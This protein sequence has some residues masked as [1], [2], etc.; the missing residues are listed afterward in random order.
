M[1]M[2][3]TKMNI[4]IENIFE[5]REKPEF[6]KIERERF[7]LAMFSCLPDSYHSELLDKFKFN[8]ISQIPKCTKYA[9]P[10]NLKFIQTDDYF[11]DWKMISLSVEIETLFKLEEAHFLNLHPVRY[12]LVKRAIA[13]GEIDMPIVYLCK[14]GYPRVEDGRHRIMALSKFGFT[15]VDIIVPE[16][17][18]A[19]IKTFLN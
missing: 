14:E 13:A 4:P 6:D 15:H 5:L 10:E 1:K 3:V 8:S 11:C 2:S 17:Q 16:E 18:L 9:A 19:I 7:N 12:D